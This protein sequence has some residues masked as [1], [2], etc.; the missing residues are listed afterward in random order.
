MA[1]DP[2]H[3]AIAGIV[4]HA[5][6]VAVAAHNI[7]NVNTEGFKKSRA[8]IESDA[9]GQPDVKVTQSEPP[10]PMIPAPEGLPGGAEFV[11]MSNVNLAEEIVQI[12]IAKYA[13]SASV[14]IISAQDQMI[15]TILDIIV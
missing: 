9:A 8:V 1:V 12:Q 6:K 15:G 11:E 7:A 3:S 2:L 10:G 14:S 13:Y 4:V 5:E